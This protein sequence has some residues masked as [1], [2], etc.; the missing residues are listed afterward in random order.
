MSYIVDRSATPGIPPSIVDM[1]RCPRVG[2]SLRLSECVRCDWCGKLRCD[3]A[4]CHWEIW[5]KYPHLYPKYTE[6]DE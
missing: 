2:A 3:A 6:V 5:T 4:R 1:R